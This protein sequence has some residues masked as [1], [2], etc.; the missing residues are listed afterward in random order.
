MAYKAAKAKLA[1]GGYRP[2]PIKD[3]DCASIGEAECAAFP[4]IEACSGT[5][6][7]FCSARYIGRRRVGYNVITQGPGG[8]LVRVFRANAP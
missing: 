1:R 7:G 6:A 8:S 3:R 2:V 4:E 5:G